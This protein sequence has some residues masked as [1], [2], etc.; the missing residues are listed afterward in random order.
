MNPLPAENWFKNST[1]IEQSNCKIKFPKSPLVHSMQE[2]WEAVLRFIKFPYCS[3]LVVRPA[4]AISEI[5]VRPL[6]MLEVIIL[7]IFYVFQPEHENSFSLPNRDTLCRQS[8]YQ[9]QFYRVYKQHLF[10]FYIH[11]Y[12]YIYIWIRFKKMWK[13]LWISYYT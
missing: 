6:W 8:L 9:P 5:A 4:S 13:K 12:I 10:L 7:S 2:N 3:A 1:I 11:I